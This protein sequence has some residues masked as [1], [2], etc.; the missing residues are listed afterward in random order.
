MNNKSFILLCVALFGL[1][2][3]SFQQQDPEKFL[4]YL[5]NDAKALVSG[6][7]VDRIIASV[8][9][10]ES[11]PPEVE[12]EELSSRAPGEWT[13]E[14][15]TQGKELYTFVDDN[16]KLDVHGPNGLNV[17][18]SHSYAEWAGIED[19]EAADVFGEWVNGNVDFI[20]EVAGLEQID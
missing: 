11:E 1:F 19:W 12:F 16:G 3:P 18:V 5:E 15:I 2:A 13:F 9:Q 14:V 10:V 17:D 7:G 4:D 8:P 6:A 20:Y